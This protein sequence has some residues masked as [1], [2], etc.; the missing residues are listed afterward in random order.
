MS[1]AVIISLTALLSIKVT[2]SISCS[3]TTTPPVILSLAVFVSICVLSIASI[4]ACTSVGCADMLSWFW[5][6]LPAYCDSKF[7][8]D[9]I[10]EDA[11]RTYADSA[12]ST[13]KVSL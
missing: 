9:S 8:N 1:V 12:E 10:S 7:C 11:M 6:G 3:G 13:V 2:L 4:E 5:V